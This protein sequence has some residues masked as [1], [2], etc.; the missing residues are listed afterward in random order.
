MEGEVLKK[1]GYVIASSYRLRVMKA[2][3]DDVKIPK[4]VAEDCGLDQ[5]YISKVLRDLRDNDLAE[6]MRSPG[7]EGS[8]D[9][10]MWA[11]R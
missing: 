11:R 10:R 4:K 8:T 6:S 3:R 7:R 9:S 2:L 1:Y 5:R